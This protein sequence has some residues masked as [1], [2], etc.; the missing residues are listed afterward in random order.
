[1]VASVGLCYFQLYKADKEIENKRLIHITRILR[2]SSDG[3]GAEPLTYKYN[4]I[5]PTLLDTN[6]F[7][8]FLASRPTIVKMW[9]MFLSLLDTN[10]FPPLLGSKDKNE[11]KV[12]LKWTAPGGGRWEK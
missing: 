2:C 10:I 7:P 12:K 11:K 3:F 4:N 6:L 5:F 8:V 9:N 1:M